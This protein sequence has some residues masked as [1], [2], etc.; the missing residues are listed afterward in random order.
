[1]S[2]YRE[3]AEGEGTAGQERHSS[4]TARIAIKQNRSGRN[5]NVFVVARGSGVGR[6]HQCAHRRRGRGSFV[7][8]L[9]AAPR[10]L[11]RRGGR[12]SRARGG[13]GKC[14]GRRR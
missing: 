2:I 12:G 5:V 7:A 11:G 4:L 13:G 1:M 3:T 14:D 10:R 8:V 9:R 6:R